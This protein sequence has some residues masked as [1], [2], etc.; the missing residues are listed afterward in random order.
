MPN[1]LIEDTNLNGL[2]AEITYCPV[3]GSPIYLGYHQLPFN[4]VTT[5]YDGGTFSL[6]YPSIDLQC[7]VCPTTTTST[8]STTTSSTTTTTT[9]CCRC[10][11]IYM[12]SGIILNYSYLPCEGTDVINGTLTHYN[13]EDPFPSVTVCGVCSQEPVLY[14]VE[15]STGVVVTD[16]STCSLFDE[17]VPIPLCSC[18]VFTG[19]E[20][21]VE[22]PYTNCYGNPDSELVS[23]GLSI[24]VCGYNPIP[25]LGALI[26]FTGESCVVDG[27]SFVCPADCVCVTLF[28]TLEGSTLYYGYTDCNYNV[29][30]FGEPIDAQETITLCIL[31]GTLTIDFGI[32]VDNP[33]DTECVSNEFGGYQCMS[34]T[35]TT[36]VP[37]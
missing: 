36:T 17:C 26:E 2:F 1:I 24:S 12:T 29:V 5:L 7:G 4:W 3:S 10:Y 16:Y 27:E 13:S 33:I 8:S 14:S 34:I 6:Y 20:G 30:P 19:I 21:T 25:T 32:S 28:N 15:A 35:T 22:V 11:T 23:Y 18:I 31:Q 37:F 9:S